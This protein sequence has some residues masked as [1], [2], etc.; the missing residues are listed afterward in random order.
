M[1][2]IE[3]VDKNFCKFNAKAILQEYT[4]GQTKEIPEYKLIGET[5]PAHNKTFEVEVRYQQHVIA[6]GSGKSKKE[7]EQHAAYE[8]CKKLGAIE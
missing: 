8:A 7:A 3:D 6:Q 4:Q 1:P 2:Y 5:G